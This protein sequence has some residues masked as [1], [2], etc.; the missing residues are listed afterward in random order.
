MST[1]SDQRQPTRGTTATQKKQSPQPTKPTGTA[2]SQRKGTWAM[3]TDITYIGADCST[4]TSSSS[5]S[6]D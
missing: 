3:Y 5:D 2:G 4:D 1:I 6:C